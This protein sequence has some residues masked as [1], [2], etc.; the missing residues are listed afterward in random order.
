MV[1]TG[2]RQ[3]IF[4]P[5]LYYARSAARARLLLGSANLTVGGLRMNIEASV[6]QEFDSATVAPFLDDLEG[7]LGAMI[8]DYPAHVIRAINAAQLADLMLAGR[9]VDERKARPTEPVGSST[10]PLLDTLP[11][12]QLRTTPIAVALAV[13]VAPPV[14]PV[15]PLPIPVAPAA[16]MAA[17]LE[18]EDAALLWTSKPLKRAH[19]N[20]PNKA[21]TNPKVALSLSIGAQ[22]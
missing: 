8:A 11:P 16:P 17:P 3:R 21:G 13:P 20:L 5:K 2:S 10:N 6:L 4:H 12:M 19:I 14:P 22:N 18:C 15:A 1:D 7:K 9:L